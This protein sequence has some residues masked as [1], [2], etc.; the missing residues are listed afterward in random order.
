MSEATSPL[1]RSSSTSTSCSAA[2]EYRAVTEYRFV[3]LL[4]M[5]AAVSLLLTMPPD[6]SA[7]PVEDDWLLPAALVLGP[8]LP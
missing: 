3:F 7:A 4:L 8:P 5:L 1:A 6:F 2:I